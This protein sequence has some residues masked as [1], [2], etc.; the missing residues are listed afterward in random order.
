M[1]V[2]MNPNA[3]K[4]NNAA[5][6]NIINPN[7]S[8]LQPV[9]PV[10]IPNPSMKPTGIVQPMGKAQNNSISNPSTMSPVAPA[11]SSLPIPTSNVLNPNP[12]FAKY[13][14]K[15]NYAASQNTRWVDA[16]KNNDQ[17][18]MAK[19]L[20][21]SKRA[22]YVLNPYQAPSA[23]NDTDVS[24]YTKWK[25]ET[26]DALNKYKNL[27]AGQ[28]NF[29]PETDAGYQAQRQLAALRAKDANRSTM[30]T[31]NEKGLLQSTVTNS[32]LDQNSQRAEQEA[33]A[34]I[35]E[36]RQQA[37]GQFGDKINRAKDMLDYS[38]NRVD[39]MYGR[40]YQEGRDKVADDQQAWTNRYNYGTAIGK[41]ANGRE[42][43]EAQSQK[44]NQNMDTKNFEEDVRR[45]EKNYDRGKYESDR[46][47]RFEV[48]QRAI[49]NG[50]WQSQFNMDVEKFGFTKA[51][52]LWSQAFQE[53]QAG[54]DDAY[55]QATLTQSMTESD[56]SA[57]SKAT[58][59][60]LKSNLVTYSKNPKTGAETVTVKDKEGLNNYIKSLRLSDDATDSLL[61]QYGLGSYVKK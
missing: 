53:N 23:Q 14:G 7:Q 43:L 2:S 26:D 49:S 25:T 16:N 48:Q 10:P 5:V 9:K 55:R 11:A 33:A 21:D 15:D 56:R 39:T 18:L 45:Y 1:P 19:L 4:K 36:Y 35:P 3:Q 54:Q 42:T 52:D 57:A 41:F 20:A 50:Q 27:A 37:Y 58:D 6:A 28:F 13:G 38:T 51:S 12:T 60:I 47:Y 34:Y 61:Y 40:E 29:D 31:M 17:E 46:N 59:D 30:E 8:A 32:Q 22:N 24:D 44:F